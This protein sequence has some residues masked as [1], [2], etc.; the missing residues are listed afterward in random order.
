LISEIERSVKSAVERERAFKIT[1]FT[2]ILKI[3]LVK[4]KK[5]LKPT[6]L[7]AMELK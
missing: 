3:F 2:K 6:R 1:L 7:R 5:L 4:K